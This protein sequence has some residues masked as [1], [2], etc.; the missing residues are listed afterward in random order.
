MTLQEVQEGTTSSEFLEWQVFLE[1]E[2]NEHRREDY[3]LAAIAAEVR[4]TISKSPRGVRVEDHL[5]RFR[6]AGSARKKGPSVEESKAF[7]LGH[8]MRKEKGNG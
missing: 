6:P 3:Y 4:R 8:L 7:W 5:L 1:K 2:M